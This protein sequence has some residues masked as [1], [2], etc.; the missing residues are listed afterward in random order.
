MPR[1]VTGGDCSGCP[2]CLYTCPSDVTSYPPTPVT[3]YATVQ[4]DPQTPACMLPYPPPLQVYAINYIPDPPSGATGWNYCSPADTPPCNVLT[5][6]GGPPGGPCFAGVNW[7]GYYIKLER[8][9]HVTLPGGGRKCV[10][11]ASLIG[12]AI[13]GV[14]PFN[15][16]QY[17]M[18]GAGDICSTTAS[19]FDIPIS[20]FVEYI[21][22]PYHYSVSFGTGI[23][24]FD[25]NP[26]LP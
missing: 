9:L 23:I 13:G 18:I 5:L 6:P 17:E 24:H 1:V 19:S 22:Y 21:Q 7:Y 8:G 4:I 15:P 11:R 10:F 2:C 25:R 20:T 12:H 26:I 16:Q 3:Y 14:D